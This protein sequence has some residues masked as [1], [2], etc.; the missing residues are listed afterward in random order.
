MLLSI[1]LPAYK[2]QY[3]EK[4]IQSILD[5]TF[6]D[7]ELIILNDA[8]PDPIKE[9][10]NKFDDPRISYFINEKNEGREDL[11][12]CWNMVL[13]KASGKYF[14]LASDDDY[15]EPVFLEKL[16]AK[17]QQFPGIDIFHCRL[18]LVD[19]FGETTDI[20]SKRNE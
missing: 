20:T 1:G 14:V 10:I 19:A 2:S 6:R 11:A 13:K 8:S 7:F 9:V 16:V 3:L 4:A 15:Y 17:A 12:S 5:Q 18:R